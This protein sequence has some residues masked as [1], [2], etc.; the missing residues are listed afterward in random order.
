MYLKRILG[1]LFLIIFVALATGCRQ[2]QESRTQ[3]E[4]N[5]TTMEDIKKEVKEMVKTTTSY[6]LEQRNAYEKQLAQKIDA[7]GKKI[8]ALKEQMMIAKG[9]AEKKLQE[10]IDMLQAKTDDLKNKAEDLRNATG[11]AWDELKKGLDK[12][13]DDL[14]EAFSK[15]MQSYTK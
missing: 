10:Q 12:A 4:G 1:I 15:A 8:Q 2:R 3:E 5:K 11:Q 7:Y 9:E 13:V 6:S 14:D